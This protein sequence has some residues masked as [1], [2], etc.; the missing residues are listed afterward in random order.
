MPFSLA[1]QLTQNCPFNCGICNTYINSTQTMLPFSTLTKVILKLKDK[2]LKRFTITGGEP[3]LYKDMVFELLD[4]LNKNNI[5]TCLSTTGLY[6][7]KD[8]I[9]ELNKYLDHLMISYPHVN[10][11][12]WEN[13]FGIVNGITLKL[14]NVVNFLID[15]LKN[16][17]INLEVVTVL[18]RLNINDISIIGNK[19]LELNKN[20]FWKIEAYY[21]N[22]KNKDLYNLYEIFDFEYYRIEE[23]ITKEFS[24]KFRSIYFSNRNIFE[25]KDYLIAPNGDIIRTSN[26]KY[27][28]PIGNIMK[29]FN[30][31]F[32]MTRNWND[33]EKYF[34]NW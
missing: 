25:S 23:Q 32:P 5:R 19:L 11:K 4:F 6:L 7:K 8:S 9:H 21:S 33:Y 15:Y 34:R 20:I 18:N 3:L 31:E 27:S 22:G 29:D 14:F 30:V 16:T 10:Y 2:G 17:Q 12:L 1:Y 28:D 13:H 26:N 24:G